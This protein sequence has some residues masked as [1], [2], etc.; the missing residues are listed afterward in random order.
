MPRLLDQINQPADLRKLRVED[1]PLLSAEIRE[2]IISTVSQNGGHLAPSLG[3]V[4]LTIALHYV[5]DTPRDRIIWDVGHQTYAHKILTGRRESFKTIRTKG[6]LSGFPKRSE[7]QYDVFDTGHAST[8][9]S[10]GLGLSVG[11]ELQGLT[12]RVIAVIGDGSLTGGMAFE[13]LNQAG[14]LGKNLTVILNDN[15]MSI[16]PNVGA[17]SSFLSRKMTHRAHIAL[18]QE[19]KEFLRS[20]PG[21]GESVIKLVQRSEGSFRGFLSPSYLFEAFKFEYIGPIRGHRYDRLLEALS[22]S[23]NVEGPVLV[24]VLTTKGKGYAPAEKNPVH[25]HGVGAFQ[26][27]TG[28]PK[29]KAG[30]P[31]SYTEVF[32]RFMVEAAEK[33]PRVVAV[34]AAMP[35][36]TGL[37]AFGQKFPNRFFDVGI[38]EQ[39]AVT[40]AAGLALEG[41]R[42]VV[43]IYS[44]FLQRAFDQIFHDVCLQ[45][46]P[47]LFAMDRGG[48]VGED[49][50]T[51]HGVLDLSYLR[52]LPGLTIMAPRDENE[53]RRML[54]TG[55]LHH[56]PSTVRYPRGI[57]LGVALP[58]QV[59]PLPIGRGEILKPGRDILILAVGSTV[60]PALAAAEKL[61][62]RGVEAALVDAKFVKPLDE[63]LILDLAAGAKLVLCV[64]EN[65]IIGGF[66]SAVCELLAEK[67]TGGLGRVKRLGVP[68][69]PVEHG[70]QAQLRAELGL[71]RDGIV[72]SAL[73]LLGSV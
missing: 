7:S 5:F 11:L 39:H 23:K 20:V 14:E 13:G 50:P 72:R 51:H 27:E 16:S 42:P 47:V 40:F 54:A 33:D 59:Q 58:D 53:L 45:N 30:V 34:T 62:G 31:P 61:A 66:G 21:V 44:T 19:I 12:D 73:D 26:I 4:E 32:G 8:S 2:E 48:L 22:N 10:A 38:A 3:V 60:Y 9:L 41:F 49:G 46:L 63:E 1:L 37:T 69:R 68:D 55:L 71:D 6:G 57:G 65:N 29:K 15:E 17:L 35:E 43:A 28:D 36:G 18:K 24:H 56:G 25:Y 64:E 52:S 70:P 67:G